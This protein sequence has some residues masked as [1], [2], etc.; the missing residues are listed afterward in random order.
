MILRPVAAALLSAAALWASAPAATASSE[1]GCTPPFPTMNSQF[2]CRLV[3]GAL[4]PDNDT[5]DNLIFL[6]A[7]RQK[8]AF[9]TWPEPAA[10]D[11]SG[12][13]VGWGTVCVSDGSGGV[14]FQSAIEA[15]ATVPAGEKALLRAARLALN[16][17]SNIP[18]PAVAA[19]SAS[20]QAFAA[21]LAAIDGFYRGSHVDP[22]P[23]AALATSAQPW[24]REAAQYMQAR[25]A[26]LAAQVNAFDEWGTMD[27]TRIDPAQVAAA[28]AALNAYRAAYPAGAYA[29][30]AKG[31]LRRADWLDGDER[32]LAATYS[33]LVTSRTV[34]AETVALADEVDNKL[35]L[36][37]Y[38][39]ST[40]DPILLA[41]QD[42]RLLRVQLD[43]NGAVVPGMAAAVLEAQRGQFTGQEMLFDYLLALRALRVDRDADTVLR[44]LNDA[45][46]TG[47]MDYLGFS[48]RLLRAEALASKGEAVR[49]L[50][51]A[52]L[53]HTA[54]Y[55]QRNTLELAIAKHEERQK[56]I[57]YLFEPGTPLSNP[58]LRLRLLDHVAGPIILKMQA[59]AES[60]PAAER[61]GALYRLLHRDLLQGRFKGFLADVKFLPAAAVPSADGGSDDIFAAFRWTGENDSGYAC[62]DIVKIAAKL[63][64]NPKDVHGRLCLGDFFRINYIVPDDPVEADDLGGTGTL[65]AGAPLSRQDFYRDIMKDRKARR[66]DRAYALYRA[67]RCYQGTYDCGGEMVDKSV[68]KAWYTELKTGYGDTDWAKSLSYYW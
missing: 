28:R 31:L 9:A 19:A 50:Y 35:P 34:N 65:F 62:P 38:T 40:A 46:P 54:N 27:R 21:Y 26:L 61:H 15:D 30:S 42:L 20:G 14:A 33:G 56:N 12:G 68:R 60:A 2:M 3:L 67:V 23:F 57:S 63:A 32:V 43:S 29:G 44:L 11:G 58:D 7:D 49:D 25:I 48:R 8:Q 6:M 4:E 45:P 1:G 51:V 10:G 41:V 18:A 37:S 22:A 52:M 64:A 16:C 47:P 53:P 13:Y 66:S 24:V 55:Q 17:E 59:T 39:A 5:R 36:P